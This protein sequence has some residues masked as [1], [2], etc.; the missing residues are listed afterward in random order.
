MYATPLIVWMNEHTSAS[1]RHAETSVTPSLRDLLKPFCKGNFL[2][3]KI[4]FKTLVPDLVLMTD[5][6]DFG[7]SGVILPYVIRDIWSGLD[8]FRFIIVREM[9]AM[10]FFGH[11]MKST[12]AGKPVVF[13]TDSEVV[14]FLCKKNGFASLTSKDGP[15]QAVSVFV[16]EMCHY[17]QGPSY[18][19]FIKC[20][21]GR[22]VKGQTQCHRQL[23]G[24]RN[25]IILFRSGRLTFKCND[26]Y[27][28]PGKIRVAAYMSLQTDNSP[29]CVGWDDR[30]M[31]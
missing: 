20:P 7:W 12:R 6:S 19:R 4:S 27:V 1:A 29:R 2:E 17:F 26:T 3:Q 30:L 13:H 24:P 16:H 14:F 10:T 8:Q 21:C 23:P 28:L 9:L 31:D 22:M 25:F 11:F 15:G 5:A 18:S